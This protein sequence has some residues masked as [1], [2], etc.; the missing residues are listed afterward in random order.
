MDYIVVGGV[1][2]V[3]HG[4]VRLTADLDIAVGLET[5]NLKKLI[6]IM[7]KLG[8]KPAAPVKAEDLL[9]GALREKWIREKNMLA[10][11]FRHLKGP[12]L[13]D[14][15][16]STPVKYSELKKNA[17]MVKA[18]GIKIPVVSITGLIK[19]KKGSGRPQDALDVE[20]LREAKR[21]EK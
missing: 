21:H 19:M 10:F 15:M 8:Y 16:I 17:V 7:A 18:G 13:V 14:V 4:V 20:A 12:G 9:D 3:L 5:R 6:S 11:G 1:A 2:L